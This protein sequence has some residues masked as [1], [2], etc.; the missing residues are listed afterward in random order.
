[1]SPKSRLLRPVFTIQTY[2]GPN[3]LKK[4]SHVIISCLLYYKPDLH[5]KYK[6]IYA[7]LRMKD[8]IRLKNFINPTT[9]HDIVTRNPIH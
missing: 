5:H 8:T 3:N 1:M 4:K 9:R 7:K 2:D 6:P